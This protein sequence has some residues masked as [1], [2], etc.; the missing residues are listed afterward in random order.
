MSS[1]RRLALHGFAGGPG[2]WAPL[3]ETLG[4]FQATPFLPGHGERSLAP[5]E[6]FEACVGRLL[7]DAREAGLRGSSLVGYSMGA[8]LALGLLLRD[9]AFFA[10]T[11]LVGVNPG[12]G[13]SQRPDRRAW[14]ASWARTIREEG[15]D[16]FYEA[17]D[18][19]PLLAPV[20]APSMEALEA[21]RTDR[22]AHT[23][24]GLARAMT[25]LGLGAMPDYRPRL[26]EIE[27]PVTLVVGSEDAK[28]LALGRE[29]VSSMVRA[30]L[31]V[32][33]GAGHNVVLEKPEALAALLGA[34]HDR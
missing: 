18:R 15:L 27:V 17:W 7:D 6:S 32:V 28:F 1:A 23:R 16:A 11:I 34:E 26:A 30:R 33:P 2:T 31:V 3:E 21:R 24:E 20:S 5:G 25:Q 29:M 10:D 12:I 13:E 8:R 14:E 19:Q 22:R 9:P 4:P